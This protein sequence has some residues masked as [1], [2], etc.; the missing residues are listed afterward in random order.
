M[1][2]FVLVW[3]GL[4]FACLVLGCWVLQRFAAHS[5]Q[6][7][8]DRITLALWLGFGLLS[9]LLLAVAIVVPLTPWVGLGTIALPVLASL[10]HRPTVAELIRWGQL[11]TS[12]RLRKTAV[13]SYVFCCGVIALFSLQPVTWLD[14]GLY[15]YGFVRWLADHGV[16]PGLALINRQFGFV[17]AWFALLA[18][19]N[20]GI[21]AGRASTV[22]NGFV[23]L[24][25]L[26]QIVITLPQ[27]WQG[28]GPIHSNGSQGNDTCS[29]SAYDAVDDSRLVLTAA[30]CDSDRA[31]KKV[32]NRPDKR[33]GKRAG[34][35]DSAF[36]AEADFSAWFLLIFSLISLLLLTQT[37]FLSTVSVSASPDAAIALFTMITAWSM[38][39]VDGPSHRL[40]GASLLPLT[41]AVIATS[42]KLTAL[43]LL[44]ITFA[45][46]WIKQPSFLRF[47]FAS[48]YTF[49][50]LLPFLLAQIMTS[51]CPLYPSTVACFSLPWRLSTPAIN[52]L[53]ERTH[54]WGNWFG[55][56]PVGAHR[57]LWL[58]QQWIGS[59]HS[60][61]LMA[62]SVVFSAVI[63]I[64]LLFRWRLTLQSAVFWLIA[65]SWFGSGFILLKAPL[66]RFGMGFMLLLPV[67]VVA[68]LCHYIFRVVRERSQAS[69][70][71]SHF[72]KIPHRF[73]S[74]CSMGRYF[75]CKQIGRNHRAI[76]ALLLLSFI[77]PYSLKYGDFGHFLIVPP[78]VPRVETHSQ[79]LNKIDYVITQND[80]GQCWSAAL[81]CVD[82]LDAS[83][84][85][86]KP[87]VGIAGGFVL[88]NPQREF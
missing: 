34:K 64:Y 68:A 31:S 79:Q 71:T 26:L 24:L 56:P 29:R 36:F 16:T 87:E 61:K 60:S 4:C 37:H 46:Y 66:F 67:F 3:T 70:Q 14:T 9:V 63:G 49:T 45:Y 10:W 33:A 53:A 39:V 44:V 43:P 2:Y 84:Q 77:V 27:I 88:G 75:F 28:S 17:S 54:G 59:N 21:M 72:Q 83:V 80:R 30:L 13:A 15:H 41:L 8:S 35:S 62:I 18:P 74:V 22:M 50:L 48:L 86:R 1:L 55:Q 73:Q 76:F 20:S 47:L 78:S 7:L 40:I 25:A 82:S 81:P 57:Q 38:L 12:K 5:I 11:L 52:S 19:F 32:S 6:R 23:L 65:L 69:I 85:L 58:L 51:S 42:L